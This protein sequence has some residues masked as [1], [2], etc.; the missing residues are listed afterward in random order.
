MY[1]NFIN[2]SREYIYIILTATIFL[3]VSFSKSFSEEN[4]FIIDN[5]KVEGA[6]DTN[7][8]REKYINKAFINSFEKLSWKILLS[9]DLDKLKNIKLIK[10]KNL[11]ESFQILDET[12]KNEEYKA[13]FKINY[14]ERKVKKLLSDKNLSFTQ[15]KNIS[16]VFFPVLFKKEE[17]IDYKDNYFYKNWT[18]VKIENE[19]INFIIPLEDLDDIEK[20][21][22]M[23]NQIEIDDFEIKDLVTKY[24]TNNY[25]I[26]LMHQDKNQLNVFIKTNFN[27]NKVD[28]NVY[29]ETNYS[30]S[31][32]EKV[33]NSILKKLKIQITDIWK[34]ENI[35]NISIP[36]TIQFNFQHDNLKD[37]DNLKKVLS[38]ISIVE[39]Y[40]LEE[41]NINNS[42]FKIYYFG[43]PKRLKTELLEFNYQ[44]VHNQGSW[45]LRIND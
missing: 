28:K 3:S 2:K 41:L 18:A 40:L 32:K 38:N 5:V 31:D 39:D 33:L 26:A 9:R 16:A 10:I 30:D 34:E 13:D 6:I 12:F 4:V 21:K 35:V 36:L 1:K 22:K 24:N 42:I 27:E 45:E 19:L 29:Y 8:S 37:L 17:L 44:L 25:V 43:N 11:I 23:K 7:F 15:P 20:I 14:N